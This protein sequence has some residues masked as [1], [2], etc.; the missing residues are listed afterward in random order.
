MLSSSCAHIRDADVRIGGRFGPDLHDA[1]RAGVAPALLVDA[2]FL[3]R[4]R[5]DEQVIE[6]VVVRILLEEWQRLVEASAFVRR[7]RVAYPHVVRRVALEEHIAE[8]RARSVRRDELLQRRL[9]LGASHADDGPDLGIRPCHEVFVDAHVRQHAGPR[10]RDVPVA[11]RDLHDT[12]VHEVED[13]LGFEVLVGLDDLHR[14]AASRAQTRVQFLQTLEIAARA[15]HEHAPA[16]Q[17]LDARQRGRGGVRDDDL[18]HACLVRHE[19]DLARAIGRHGQTGHRDIGAPV[20]HARDELAVLDR[21]EDDL[22]LDVALLALRELSAE[23][24]HELVRKAARLQAVV[25]EERAVVGHQHADV[26]PFAHPVEVACPWHVVRRLLA[27]DRGQGAVR[28]RPGT[29][30]SGGRSVGGGRL[31]GWRWR[32][33]GCRGI[34]SGGRRSS[35]ARD[36]EHHRHRAGREAERAQSTHFRCPRIARSV[37]ACRSLYHPRP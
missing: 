9:E 2:R 27:G 32:G 15:P 11:D 5:G 17:V 26:A 19:L 10:A 23:L 6:A 20:D 14:F 34:R 30:R 1:D 13:V 22:R 33:R 8:R 3:I 28:G 12:C 36:D 7:V 24:G 4:L 18:L 25:E 35:C 31:R 16:G 29:G 21:D 37:S